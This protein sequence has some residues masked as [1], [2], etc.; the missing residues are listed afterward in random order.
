MP[1][2]LGPYS[3]HEVRDARFALDGGAMFGVVPRPL[4]ERVAP[5]DARNRIPLVT[6]CLLIEDGTRRILVDT[7]MGE[8]WTD[9]ERDIYAL[10]RSAF[11][12]DRELAR[13]GTRREEI[14]DVI[15][16]H[17]HFDH[18]GGVCRSV[19]GEPAL[20]FPNATHHLQRRNWEWAHGC[21]ERDRGSF[22]QQTFSILEQSGQLSLIEGQAELAPGVEVFVSEG[23][24]VGLQLVRVYEP[25]GRCLV[26]CA[27]LV[28]TTAHLRP[29]WAMAYDLQ[30]LTVLEE[31]TELLAQAAESGWILAFEHDP[32]I[33]ACTV[34]EVEGEIQLAEV[35]SL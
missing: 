14:T 13:A 17:L 5:P 22:R 27:D 12:L 34:R 8:L 7:G 23:H 33:A 20:S 4:W 16:T 28:P 15:L 30:P 35:I 31:K 2:R 6:R 11:D 24:T 1:L 32:N 3:L 21:S 9:R 25:E 19:D 10:D 29:A 18:A 26:F